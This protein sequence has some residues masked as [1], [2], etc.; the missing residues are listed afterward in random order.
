MMPFAELRLGLAAFVLLAAGVAANIF[1]LQ[2]KRRGGDIETSALA[3]KHYGAAETAAEP[4]TANTTFVRDGK[5]EVA[6]AGQLAARNRDAAAMSVSGGGGASKAEIIRGVQRELNTRGYGTG[7]PDGVAGL[8]TRASIMA[9]EYD[10]GL[11]LTAEPSQDLLS[12]I[13]LG[14][15]GPA[16]NLKT[17]PQ[18]KTGEAEA[19][20][21]TVKQ[22]L[23]NLG[24]ASGKADSKL[25]DDVIRAIRDFELDQKL[26]ETG[27]ISA[28]LVSRLMR[29]QG[30]GKAA[31]AVKG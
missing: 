31:A 16:P 18:I 8:L 7:Q 9:Y 6:A 5:S 23:S 17:Q 3:P 2:E 14:T 19:V 22:F 13:V 15:S 20:V 4:E 12:R 28:Q 11:S 29:L 21:K 27:R 10:Y 1:A 24:Y 30:Q 25:S 26:P